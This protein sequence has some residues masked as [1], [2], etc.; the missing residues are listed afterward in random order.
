MN[1]G[2]MMIIATLLIILCLVFVHPTEESTDLGNETVL[3][4]SAYDSSSLWNLVF[5]IKT[6]GVY[7]GYDNETVSWMESLGNKQVFYSYDE[8]VIMDYSDASKIPSKGY[9]DTTDVSVYEI[10]ECNV[11]EN[12]SLGN[13]SHPKDVLLVKNVKHIRQDTIY[14]EV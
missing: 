7:A 11:L 4:V 12:H 6:N 3:N 5:D 8:I 1:K 9:M 2:I 14:Y 13:T 10:F